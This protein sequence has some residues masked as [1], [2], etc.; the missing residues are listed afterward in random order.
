M[1]LAL[2]D[3]NDGFSKFVNEAYMRP[4]LRWDD[5]Q[6]ILAVAEAGGT[7]G[8]ASRLGVTQTTA[9]RRLNA[10]EEQLGVRLFERHRSGYL[11]TTAGRKLLRL[12]ERVK[13]DVTQVER[14]VLGQDDK[15]AGT[16][17]ITAPMSISRAMGH[18]APLIRDAY[19]DIILDLRLASKE[20]SLADREADIAIRA[21]HTPNESL[22][23]RKIGQY[24]FAPFRAVG[25]PE[26][27]S[28]DWIGLIGR[29]AKDID[30]WHQEAYPE[31]RIVIRTEGFE[32][33]AELAQAGMGAVMLPDWPRLPYE[34]LERV[35]GRIPQFTTPVWLLVHKDL[36]K[37]ARVRIVLDLLAEHLA[38]LLSDSPSEY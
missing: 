21:S 34:G 9:Y 33:A 19:P 3:C 2:Q 28:Q 10:A 20:L 4:D 25:A 12:A 18:C 31:A 27:R 11:P 15:P 37:V 23:G 14:E 1:R 5:L 16:V 22:F 13:A 30:R 36:R 35:G 26:A 8:A 17:V 24:Y 38:G 29:R 6:L 32:S 7:Q